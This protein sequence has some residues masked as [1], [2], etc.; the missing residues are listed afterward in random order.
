MTK[1]AVPPGY[2]LIR[3]RS[4]HPIVSSTWRYA[5]GP[6]P[7]AMAEV[8]APEIA[9]KHA[10]EGRERCSEKR[11]IHVWVSVDNDLYSDEKL[12][13]MSATKEMLVQE[14]QSLEQQAAC[15]QAIVEKLPA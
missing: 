5:Y 13:D 1:I 2:A 3:V 8:L 14:I 15:L 9:R 6:M 12:I 11:S 10:E 4:E 7:Q